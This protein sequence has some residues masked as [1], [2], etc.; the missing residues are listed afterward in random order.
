M[1]TGAIFRG[2]GSLK[3]P[4]ICT[5]P[6]LF[7]LIR[8]MGG[9]CST[10]GRDVYRVLVGKPEGKRSLGKPRRRWEDNI[11][12]DLQDVG[13]EALSGLVWLKIGTGGRLL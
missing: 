9:A 1:G 2:G 6:I 7:K 5:H 3:R 12:M 8:M 13:G 10:Q 11:T 4:G